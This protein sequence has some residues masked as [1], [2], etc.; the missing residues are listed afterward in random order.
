MT[1]P[2]RRDRA[3]AGTSGSAAFFVLDPLRLGLALAGEALDLATWLLFRP[4][5]LNPLVVG[6]GDAAAAAKVAGVL[7]IV[8][9]ASAIG[10]PWDR[11]VLLIACAV[12]IFG[13]ASNIPPR[14]Y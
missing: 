9:I 8:A 3:G 4:V 13:A 5:E 11:R 1:L 12:G 6:L 10:R 2:W 7:A 14:M